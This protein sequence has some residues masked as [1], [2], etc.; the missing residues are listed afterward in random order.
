MNVDSPTNKHTNSVLKLRIFQVYKSIWA[1]FKSAVIFHLKASVFQ[2]GYIQA[3][4][5][6]LE[7]QNEQ[8]KINFNKQL[9]AK[10]TE[11]VPAASENGTAIFAGTK[12][13]INGYTSKLPS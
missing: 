8:R 7:L 11:S 4:E 12:I 5:R 9:S 1:L 3:K 6:K 13:H 10:S 2:G